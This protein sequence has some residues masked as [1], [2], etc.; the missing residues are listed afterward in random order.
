MS[1]ATPGPEEPPDEGSTFPY[2]VR[3][4]EAGPDGLVRTSTLLRYAQDVAWLDSDRHGFDRAWY[5]ARGLAWVVRAVEL[6]IAEPIPLGSGLWVMTRVAGMRKVWARRRADVRAADGSLAA[7]LHTD[8]VLVD[9]GGRL[10]RVP[11]AF[12]EAFRVPHVAIEMARVAPA[13]PPADATRL[14]LRARPHELDPMGHVNNAAY[15]DWLE[16]TLPDVQL[17]AGAVASAGTPAPSR[18]IPR[19][20]VLDYAASAVPG[21]DL[22]AESWP[23]DGGWRHRLVRAS[24]GEELF[25]ALVR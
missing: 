19:R 6:E 9:G 16:E 2:R 13:P 7:W 5:R 12:P 4:D 18:A 8:W 1:A 15:V 11:P 10:V 14:A 25:R 17:A 3:F 24:D 20:Y 22:R 21:E 23:A